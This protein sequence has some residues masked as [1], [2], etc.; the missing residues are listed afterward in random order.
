MCQYTSRCPVGRHRPGTVCSY[1][2]TGAGR[3]SAH[4]SPV[5]PQPTLSGLGA[6][7]SRRSA[8]LASTSATE[9][10]DSWLSGGRYTRASVGGG[11]S[12]ADALVLIL[13]TADSDKFTNATGAWG[14]V[15]IA[16]LVLV[17]FAV[18]AWLSRHCTAWNGTVEGRCAK[19]RPQ[20]LRRC[21]ASPHDHGAQLLTLHE[22]GALVSFLLGLLGIVLLLVLLLSWGGLR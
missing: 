9:S 2:N 18:A 14:L 16:V 12:V 1:A 21:E 19:V 8:A 17:P 11:A 20:P 5:A 3:T 4:P 6:T 22:V 10:K 13:I 7:N 15:L